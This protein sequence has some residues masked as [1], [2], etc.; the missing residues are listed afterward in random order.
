ML[1]LNMLLQILAPLFFN[2]FANFFEDSESSD[3]YLCLG[4]PKLVP[5][6]CVLLSNLHPKIGD[7]CRGC[8]APKLG[9]RKSKFDP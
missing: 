6:Y 3:T 7:F 9:I 5:Y 1:L 4:C 2:K 8:C